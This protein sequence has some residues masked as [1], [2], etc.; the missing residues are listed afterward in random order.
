MRIPIIALL[1]LAVILIATDWYIIRDIKSFIK[2]SF[3]RNNNRWIL[4]LYTASIILGVGALLFLFI[5]PKRDSEIDIIAS[6]WC[7][8]CL[9]TLYIGKFVYTVFSLLSKIPVLFGKQIFK[10]LRYIGLT[11]DLFILFFAIHGA[12]YTV[13][14]LE[15]N[16]IDI[17]SDKI[18]SE[19]DGFKIAQFS[20]IHL[21]SWGNDTSFVSKMVTEINAL[22]PDVIVFTGDIVNRK[23]SEIQ[24]FVNV[25]SRLKAPYGVF[26]ILGNHDYGD[27]VDWKHPSEKEENLNRLLTLQKNMNWKL[28]DNKHTYLKRNN[29]S[30]I[31][32]GVGNWGEPPFKCYGSLNNALK[33]GNDTITT[34]GDPRFKILLTH[35]PE[36][37]RTVV[38]QETDIDLSLSGHTHAMQFMI[39]IGN[40]KW[41]PASFKY[42]QWGGLYEGIN[43]TGKITR[44]Y[45]NIGAGEVGFR[46]RIGAAVPE[47]TLFTLK[48]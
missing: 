11:L 37:W 8:Y 5:V 3:Q 12:V 4:W 24:P 23:A 27:Y 7:L 14:S 26:S 36:H 30:I 38:S 32:I 6:M 2:S 34:N 31:L 41:S 17:V 9:I 40:W 33:S 42:K 16:R 44:I 47:I 15:V 29:D 28:L 35:N 45:V 46:A 1:C 18:P 13:H 10:P 39:R 20:D 19:F 21:G 43:A 48:R 22:N 25:L